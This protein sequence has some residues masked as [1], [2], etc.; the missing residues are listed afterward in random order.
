MIIPEYKMGAILNFY[1]NSQRYSKVKV[2]YGVN[3]N[4]KKM[5]IFEIGS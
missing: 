4:G 5:T 1:E 3:D 2:I